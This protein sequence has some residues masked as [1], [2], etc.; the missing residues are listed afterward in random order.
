MLSEILLALS[1]LLTIIFSFLG[2]LVI[3]TILLNTIFDFLLII[4][5]YYLSLLLILTTLLVIRF[6]FLLA[7]ILNF[8]S[9]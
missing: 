2:C 6:D 5:F 1:T 4:I 9:F 8:L 3:L 7:I